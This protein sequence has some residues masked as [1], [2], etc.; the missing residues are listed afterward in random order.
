[1]TAF[2]LCQVDVRSYSDLIT[3]VGQFYNY[4]WLML[5][6]GGAIMLGIIGV[7]IPYI[8]HQYQKRVFKIE[9]DKFIVSIN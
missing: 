2:S 9:E 6:G 1:M 3:Q 5:M 7:L 4:A 8:T